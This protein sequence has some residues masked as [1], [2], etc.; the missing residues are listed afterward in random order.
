M[1]EHFAAFILSRNPKPFCSLNHFTFLLHRGAPAL[2]KFSQ[3]GWK[4][5]RKKASWTLKKHGG[6]PLLFKCSIQLFPV[7]RHRTWQ[8]V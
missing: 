1:D 6:Q 2:L 8:H 7:G 4:E 5:W 3:I